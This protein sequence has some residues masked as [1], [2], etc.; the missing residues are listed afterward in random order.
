VGNFRRNSVRGPSF[1]TVDA[2]LSRLVSLG[3]TQRVAF[4]VEAFNPFNTF[5]R[6]VPD[7]NFNLPAFGR[8]TSMAGTPR[9]LQVGIRYTF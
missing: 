2:S 9:I 8:I 4:R 5:N 7:G 6:D 1:W 3:A